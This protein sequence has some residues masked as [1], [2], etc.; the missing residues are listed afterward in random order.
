M[1]TIVLFII[2]VVAGVAYMGLESTWQ[3]VRAPKAAT[4]VATN[5]IC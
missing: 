3:Q 1:R 4:I 2:T 5:I